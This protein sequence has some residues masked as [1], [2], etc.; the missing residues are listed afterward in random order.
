M[1]LN[2][3][4]IQRLVTTVFKDLKAKD[5]IQFK[6]KEDK[7]YDRAVEIVRADYHRE[8]LLDE[9]VNKMMDQLE[10]QNPGQFERYKMF[11]MLK[12]RL[13][14]EKGIIL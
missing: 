7:V 9:E 8:V 10:R 5:L 6:Q 12:K 3:K 11:P 2:D 14:K 4:Q 13:A 1:K